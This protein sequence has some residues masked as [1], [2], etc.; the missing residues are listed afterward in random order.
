MSLSM[1]I[2][3]EFETKSKSLELNFRRY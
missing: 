1:I 2:D 3:I